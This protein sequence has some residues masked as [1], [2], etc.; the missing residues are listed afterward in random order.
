MLDW[1]VDADRTVERWE[2]VWRCAILRSLVSHLLWGDRLDVDDEQRDRLESFGGLFPR[3]REREPIYSQVIDIIEQAGHQA[4]LDGYLVDR[5]WSELERLAGD[6]MRQAK[7]VCFYVDALDDKFENAPYQ[8]LLCQLGLFKAV[9]SFLREQKLGGR[10]HVVI[11]VRDIVLSSTMGS[12]HLTKYLES[13]WIRTLEWDRTAIVYFIEHKLAELDEEY[14]MAPDASTSVERWLGIG[15]IRNEARDQEEDMVDYLLRHTRLIPR[16]IVVLGNKLCELIDH[17]RHHGQPFLAEHEVREVVQQAARRFGQ[18]ELLIAANHLTAEAMPPGAEGEG[19]AEFYTG[20]MQPGRPYQ[21]RVARTLADL[22]GTL[23]HDRF[24]RERMA[25]F[26]DEACLLMDTRC[27]V[28]DVLWRHGLLGFVEGSVRDG[29]VVFY[30]A[31]REDRLELP[32]NK[33]GYA[34]HPILIDTVDDLKG[35]GRPVHPY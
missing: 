33:R 27:S 3:Y 9:M 25:Q 29:R 11:G 26:E 19:Y 23:E 4:A 34:L 6:I 12:E 10:L 15:K 20:E 30:S 31:A 18:E 1:Y 24:G 16:D 8:W 28:P 7:P 14:L 13:P 22:I 35:V 5:R 2:E 32:P 17:A 21:K